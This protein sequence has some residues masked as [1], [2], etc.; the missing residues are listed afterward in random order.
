M[1]V[2]R[3][4][5]AQEVS[6][7]RGGEEPLPPAIYHARQQ[8]IANANAL[9]AETGEDQDMTPM[10]KELNWY[11]FVLQKGLLFHLCGGC[12]EKFIKDNGKVTNLAGG[13]RM[14][15]FILCPRCALGNSS[16]KQAY[17]QTW[18]NAPFQGGNGQQ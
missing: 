5:N 12:I 16:M 10:P 4:G 1:P 15:S 7:N 17:K 6:M 11:M 9:L 8:G 2:R 18:P 14:I 3:L 13:N